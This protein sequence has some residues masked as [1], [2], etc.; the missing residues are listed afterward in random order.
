MSNQDPNAFSEI[1]ST[2]Y[3]RLV[4]EAFYLLRDEQEAKDVVQEIFIDLWHKHDIA[5]IVSVKAY[6]TQSVRNRCLNLLKASKSREQKEIGYQYSLSAL[7]KETEEED[8]ATLQR[9]E[10]LLQAIRNLPPK[11]A[12]IFQLYYMEKKSRNDVAMEVGVSINTVKTVLSR[13]LKFLR[14]KIH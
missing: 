6:L 2:H 5:E 12:R 8:P 4:M 7:V 3:R 1:F 9:T 14:G 10:N 11:T 13:A